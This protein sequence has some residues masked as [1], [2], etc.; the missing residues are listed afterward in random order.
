MDFFDGAVPASISAFYNKCIKSIFC[1]HFVLAS[2]WA[3]WQDELS[4]FSFQLD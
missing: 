1:L 3:F 2:S 4:F